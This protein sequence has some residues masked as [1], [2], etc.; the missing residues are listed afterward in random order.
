VDKESLARILTTL[1]NL[2]V[3]R[4]QREQ[5]M[6]L[7]QESFRLAQELNT[8]PLIALTLGT[9][10]TVALF[11]GDYPQAQQYFVERSAIAIELGDLPTVAHIKLKLATIALAAKDF[12]QTE[13]LL[14]DALEL[15]QNLGDT[16]DIITAQNI[17][18][19][20]KYMEGDI[21]QARAFY[22]EALQ[23]DNA[24]INKRKMGHSLLG[25]A[26]V[27]LAQNMPGHA[28]YLLGASAACLQPNDMYPAH[29]THF[30]QTKEHLSTL[31]DEVAFARLWD[32]GNSTSREE[33]LDRL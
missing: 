24:T 8:R 26:Q 11:Q 16:S 30:Q 9:L 18:G 25:L 29:H 17:L 21:E 31:M 6:Q 5:A 33:I 28:T 1:V 19:D 32:E 15:L 20:L 10:G 3:S 4:G 22:L 13:K 14:D 27:S 2:E 7:A 12:G 23:H